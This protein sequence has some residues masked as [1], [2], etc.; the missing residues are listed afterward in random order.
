MGVIANFFEDENNLRYHL[1]DNLNIKETKVTKEMIDDK[2]DCIICL[3]IFTEENDIIS[4]NCNHT[5]HS[6]CLKIWLSLRNKICPTC[7]R[8]I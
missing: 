1:A 3:C 5:Y 7:K 6:N 4:L 8:N 2:K